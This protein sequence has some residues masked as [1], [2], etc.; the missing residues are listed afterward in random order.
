MKKGWMV[1]GDN[2]DPVRCAWQ[3]IDDVLK[4][5]FTGN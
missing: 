2:T 4:R 5:K 1:N 3:R